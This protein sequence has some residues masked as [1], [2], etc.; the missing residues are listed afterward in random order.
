[1]LG[2][3]LARQQL[4]DA[5]DDQYSLIGVFSKYGIPYSRE[6]YEKTYTPDWYRTY[7]A[8][9][10]PRERWEEADQLWTRCYEGEPSALLSAAR[11]FIVSIRN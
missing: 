1:M 5:R 3:F 6:Q 9:G 4:R 8:V 11:F 2:R 10:L 7:E